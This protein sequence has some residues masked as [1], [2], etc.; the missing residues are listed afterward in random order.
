MTAKFGVK[1]SQ[2]P[3]TKEAWMMDATYRDVSGTA[4]FNKKDTIA[5][6]KILSNNILSCEQRH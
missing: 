4:T 3:K 1:L 6:T 5:I 2:I